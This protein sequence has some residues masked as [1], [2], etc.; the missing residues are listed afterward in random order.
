MTCSAC[1]RSRPSVFFTLT[2][3]QADADR[4]E[5]NAILHIRPLDDEVIRRESDRITLEI[6]RKIARAMIEFHTR[7]G[8]WPEWL[9]VEDWRRPR[10]PFFD[11]SNLDSAIVQVPEVDCGDDKPEEGIASMV[12][13]AGIMNNRPDLT[14]KFFEQAAALWGTDA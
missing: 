8:R 14:A 6:E 3:T 9:W 5:L 7:E 12:Y 1:L 2:T 10:F 13:N 11:K 4:G